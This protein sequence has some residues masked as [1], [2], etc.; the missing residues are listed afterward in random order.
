V[1]KFYGMAPANETR[2]PIAPLRPKKSVFLDVGEIKTM[3]L[4]S[5]ADGVWN[6][7]HDHRGVLGVL[8]PV[9]YDPV[10]S[11]SADD[12][13]VV[14]HLVITDIGATGR[15]I[16]PAACWLGEYLNY[17]TMT[18]GAEK[19]VLVVLHGIGAYLACHNTVERYD[20]YSEETTG[21]KPIRLS[22]EPKKVQLVL[23]WGEEKKQHDFELPR[24]DS[25]KLP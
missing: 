7:S 19:L 4:A 10:K 5:A 17:A 9:Y 8:L 20:L 13:S 16:V 12:V 6:E 2:P 1:Q 24:L 18:P 25:L 22:V 3:S 11:T 21:V 15:T 14:A 23:M